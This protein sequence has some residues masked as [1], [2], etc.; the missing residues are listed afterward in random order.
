M[1][2][3]DYLIIIKYHLDNF[4]FN[5]KYL[6][7]IFNNSDN[8]FIFIIIEIE[9]RLKRMKK[10]WKYTNYIGDEEHMEQYVDLLY[11]I[12]ILKQYYKDKNIE[13]YKIQSKIFFNKLNKYHTNFWY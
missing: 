5:I 7:S 8:N 10:L 2:F 11:D 12:K 9:N 13:L 4:L 1:N 6:Y 3:R